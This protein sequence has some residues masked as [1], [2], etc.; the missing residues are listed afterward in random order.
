MITTDAFLTR[1]ERPE[2]ERIIAAWHRLLN[3]GGVVVTTVR[4]HPLDAPRG[5]ALDEVSD[6]TIRAR[7]RAARWRP[8]IRIRLDELTTAARQYAMQMRSYDL[9]DVPA[10]RK[11]FAG[12]G[13]TIEHDQTA[14]VPGE[15]RPA[16]YLRIVA[17]KSR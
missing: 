9:G 5:G 1:F 3:P 16:T 6:F 2:A 12:A 8:Y 4:I 7:D 10:I 15:L 13:F 14:R 17:R 11:L